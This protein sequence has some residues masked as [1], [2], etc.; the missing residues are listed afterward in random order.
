M[1]T[2][3]GCHVLN[4]EIIYIYIDIL[5]DMHTYNEI[6][7]IYIILSRTKLIRM[8]MLHNQFP[9]LDGMLPFL[10]PDFASLWR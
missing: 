5:I 3:T 10:A 6:C 4:L 2:F 7:H 9:F 8:V 1:T